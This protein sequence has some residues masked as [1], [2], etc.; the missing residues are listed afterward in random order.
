MSKILLVLINPQNLFYFSASE[1]P[2]GYNERK[3]DSPRPRRPDEYPKRINDRS[4]S[5]SGGKGDFLRVNGNN[6]VFSK[7]NQSSLDNNIKQN[8]LIFMFFFIS[9]CSC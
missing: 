1:Y 5:V 9:L 7:K 4:T 6:M 8:F 3:R 2:C